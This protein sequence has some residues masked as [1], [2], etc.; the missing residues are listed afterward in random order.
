MECLSVAHAG[1]GIW[2][3]RGVP[4]RAARKTFRVAA[5]KHVITVAW[6]NWQVPDWVGMAYDGMSGVL[7]LGEGVSDVEIDAQAN[8]YYEV[9]WP[10][11]DD[12][13]GP[14]GFRDVT[15]PRR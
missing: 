14:L 11:D 10:T 6:R 15:M 5:G 8:R 2:V 9:R 4:Y 3:A 1:G 13:G 7:F 12:P